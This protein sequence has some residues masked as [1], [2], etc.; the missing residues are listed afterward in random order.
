[1]RVLIAGC[2]YVGSALARMLVQ[3][4]HDVFGLRRSP[5]DLPGGVTPVTA[6]LAEG[7]GLDAVPGHLDARKPAPLRMIHPQRPRADQPCLLRPSR[8]AE[9][10]Q[11]DQRGA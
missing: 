5:S 4:G 9:T 7:V 6:D 11:R 1:M 3:D 8:C 10:G 2:G